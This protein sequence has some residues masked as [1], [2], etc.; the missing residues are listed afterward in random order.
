MSERDDRRCSQ[1]ANGRTRVEQGSGHNNARAQ[2][3]AYERAHSVREWVWR[4]SASMAC[5]S[6]GDGGR[7]AWTAVVLFSSRH[8]RRSLQ[9]SRKSCSS[10]SPKGDTGGSHVACCGGGEPSARR[11]L[12]SPQLPG[13]LTRRLHRR[14]AR[15]RT[16]Q[17]PHYL[18]LEG[19]S[20]NGNHDLP[21]AGDTASERA[22]ER[23]HWPPARVSAQRSRR[24]T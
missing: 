11:T 15:E 24:T 23:L 10:R 7:H 3:V 22:S 20:G 14:Q 18:Q 16:D 1:H 19:G 9:G 2:I 17:L 4:A 13:A 12:G 8:A 6:G 5:D 21:R